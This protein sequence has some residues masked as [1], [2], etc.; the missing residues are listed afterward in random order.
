MFISFDYKCTNTDC[1]E[2]DKRHERVHIKDEVQTCEKCSN[3]LKKMACAPTVPH[4]SWSTW[5][6]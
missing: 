6:I 1:P 4:V 5:R 3:T 2:F